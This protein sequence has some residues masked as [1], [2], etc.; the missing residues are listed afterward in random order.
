MLARL[1]RPSLAA[2]RLPAMQMATFK[3]IKREPKTVNIYERH[4]RRLGTE[5]ALTHVTDKLM[6]QFDPQGVK[7]EL[8]NPKSAD[9]IKPGDIVQIKTTDGSLFTG[10]TMVV[11]FRGLSSNLLLRSKITKIGI[12]RRFKIFSPTVE[13]VK[14]IRRATQKYTAERLYYI[15]G[16]K[17]LDVGDL[18]ASVKKAA[19]KRKKFLFK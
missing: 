5:N 3:T 15:R 19:A 12:D 7:M 9:R 1:I 10:L 11:D 2:V 18:E 16:H 6:K 8:M 14:I 13:S 17:R 4:P